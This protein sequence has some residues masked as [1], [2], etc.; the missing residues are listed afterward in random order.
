MK[1]I[2]TLFAIIL[3]TANAFAQSTE[4]ISMGPGYANNVYWS[5]PGATGVTYPIN[6]W[7]LA[8]RTGLQTS[9]IFINSANGVY[10]YH[11]P[12]TDISGW[13]TLDTT[14]LQSWQQL[15]NSDTSWEFGA[16]DR[17]S[18]G[19]PDFSWGIYDFSTHVIT[20]DSLYILKL[21]GTGNTVYKKLWIIKKDYGDWT[22]RFANLDNTDD[23]TI[24]LLDVNATGKNFSYYSVTTNQEVSEEPDNT[25]WDI[26]FTRYIT[27]LPP[28]NTPYLVTG[29]LNNVGVQA[30]EASGVDLLT[31]DP[32]AFS[33]SYTASISEI[34]YDWKYFDMNLGQY[35]IVD[36]LCYFV[37]SLSGS[38]YKVVF[39]GFDGS[40]T[41]NI[42]WEQT[43][44][45]TGI[46]S[47]QNVLESAAVYPNP[48]SS[49][50]NLIF[51]V[52]EPLKSL[53]VN[54]FNVDGEEVFHTVTTAQSGLNQ[55]QILL[56]D[57]AGGVYF[58]TLNTGD[59]AIHLKV[60]VAQ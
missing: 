13:S 19:F 23:Q 40:S 17:S 12:N 49:L 9:S 1:K 5:L 11:V 26:L 27:P 42:T 53:D 31:V 36:S 52:R 38:I 56:P 59:D 25:S 37:K 21:T 48:V 30:A 47:L 28:D 14:G 16:F 43:E 51:S 24:T 15:N 35:F 45:T 7:E 54:L 57:L 8:F 2:T 55:K 44:F 50:V 34:G 39:T 22:F 4:T 3:I 18:T 29:V 32:N 46:S 58:L 10:L 6:N 20:G 60:M 41:G 33:N